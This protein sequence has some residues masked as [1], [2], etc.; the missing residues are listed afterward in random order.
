VEPVEEV[1]GRADYFDD[2]LGFVSERAAAGY[3]LEA[4]SSL[5]VVNEKGRLVAGR[6]VLVART[7]ERVEFVIKQGA[8]PSLFALANM[9]W[10]PRKVLDFANAWG[11]LE[12]GRETD[13]A[14]LMWL[15]SAIVNVL[16]ALAS[17]DDENIKGSCDS[18]Q[19][20][21]NDVKDSLCAKVIH[22]FEI[23]EENRPPSWVESIPGPTTLREFLG[24]DLLDLICGVMVHSTQMVRRCLRCGEAYPAVRS[25]QRTCGRNACHQAMFKQRRRDKQGLPTRKRTR[26]GILSLEQFKKAWAP[27][28]LR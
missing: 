18:A 23:S 7:Q 24:L 13:V 5:S 15:S 9:Q 12:E 21:V 16:F 28:V 2:E 11:H 6:V 17:Y 4:R 14:S 22:A 8:S 3:R 25:S 19:R 1:T 10:T 20:T 26:H 27:Y